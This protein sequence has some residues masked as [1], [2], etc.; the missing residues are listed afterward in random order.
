MTEQN[1]QEDNQ[2]AIGPALVA[3]AYVQAWE[4]IRHVRNERIW[5]T[6]AYT[7]VVA[8]GLAFMLRDNGSSANQAPKSIG[9]LVLVLFS[10]LSIMSSI[11][12]VA[13]LRTSIENLKRLGNQVG[14]EQ[15][16]GMIEPPRGFGTRLPMRWV[17]PI[18][19]SLT[20]ASLVVLLIIHLLGVWG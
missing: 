8:G 20:T 12:L 3:A 16:I 4:N 15:L 19:F 7:A 13:E 1:H 9:L 14:I 2:G 10:I 17:F 6:N 5:F 18:F 11:R